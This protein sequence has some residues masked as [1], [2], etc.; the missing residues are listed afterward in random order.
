MGDL[1]LSESFIRSTIKMQIKNTKMNR[2]RRKCA[3]T[4]RCQKLTLL[5]LGLVLIASI[6]WWAFS[7]H[8]PD[9][10]RR[11]LPRGEWRYNPRADGVLD[12]NEL[13]DPLTLWT[14]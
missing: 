5:S 6:S 14:L 8:A 7:S 9:V 13:E 4:P 10:A 3:M 12:N 11:R 1:K 2:V